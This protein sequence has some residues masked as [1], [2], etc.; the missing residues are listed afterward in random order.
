MSTAVEIA[1]E[2]PKPQQQ[3][4]SQQPDYAGILSTAEEGN[5]Y[6]SKDTR[7]NSK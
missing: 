2:K 1:G 4:E 6:M 3:Y 5:T 7:M